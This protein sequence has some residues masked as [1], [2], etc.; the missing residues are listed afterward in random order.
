MKNSYTTDGVCA[1]KIDFELEDGIIKNVE[2]AKGCDGNL[3]AVANLVAGMKALDAVEKLKGIR[4][5]NRPTSCAD[6]L[7]KALEQAIK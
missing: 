3:K 5:G 6:Q 7:A 1:T 2:F 4:C